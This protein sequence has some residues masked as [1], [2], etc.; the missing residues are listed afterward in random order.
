[1]TLTA[2][3]RAPAAG[4]RAA[5]VQAQRSAA[6]APS[7]PLLPDRPVATRMRAAAPPRRVQ[8]APGPAVRE[9]LQPRPGRIDAAWSSAE[10]TPALLHLQ[11]AAGNQAVTAFVQR[12]GDH[13]PCDC[14]ADDVPVQR[15]W[16]NDAW[17]AVASVAGDAATMKRALGLA[18]AAL[19]DPGRIPALLVEMEWESLPGPVKALVVNRILDACRQL[20]KDIPAAIDPY[21]PSGLVISPLVIR[22]ATGFLDRAASYDDDK[23]VQVVNR[24]VSLWAH[25]SADFTIGFLEGLLLGVWDGIS[26]PFILIWDLV[27]LEWG[28]AQAEARFVAML[29]DGSKRKQL[30]A[31]VEQTWNGLEPKVADAIKTLLASK[32]DPTIFF[33]LMDKLAQAL[34]SGAESLGGG[35][36]DALVAYIMQPDKE[37]GKS[38]GR[39]EGNI[40]FQVLLIV[41]TAGGWAALEAAIEGIEWVADALEA[42]QNAGR[43]IEGFVTASEAF[44]K[45]SAFLRESKVLS[46]LVDILDGAFALFIKYLKF[47]YG[48]EGAEERAAGELGMTA[49]QAVEAE[50]ARGAHPQAGEG[51]HDLFD[52]A[53]GCAVCSFPCEWLQKRYSA[54]LAVPGPEGDELRAELQRIGEMTPYSEERIAAEKELQTRLERARRMGPPDPALISSMVG[55]SGR[56]AFGETRFGGLARNRDLSTLTD[57]EIRRAFEGTPYTPSSHTVMRLRDPR[58]A[59]L[60]IDTL[61]DLESLLNNGIIERSGERAVSISSGSLGMIVNPKTGVLITLTPV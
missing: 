1:M 43:A 13:A 35:L 5:K 54:E 18:E 28:V 46:E 61:K 51:G 41:L 42:L 2:V 8:A 47:S 49:D 17:N 7:R 45:F 10:L 58:T 26:G 24:F 20:V 55:K 25:P 34:L 59:A 48:I 3:R 38:I 14:A 32:T 52:T 16:Y 60:G 50:V 12:C 33:G 36:A 9:L 53:E 29:A 30:F 6:V 21:V 4:P 11:A 44:A 23:K 40:L 19:T 27:K 15:S 39:V 57:A 56:E 31:D 22:A 37:L